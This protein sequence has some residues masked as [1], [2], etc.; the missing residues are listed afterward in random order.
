MSIILLMNWKVKGKVQ[1]KYNHTACHKKVDP[2]DL[3]VKI[4]RAKHRSMQ[5]YLLVGMLLPS[6]IPYRCFFPDIFK[7]L[8][9]GFFLW[10]ITIN[11]IINHHHDTSC[12]YYHK[13]FVFQHKNSIFLVI[14][15]HLLL[16]LIQYRWLCWRY[17]NHWCYVH[18]LHNNKNLY[19]PHT[20]CSFSFQIQSCQ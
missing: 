18:F 15:L 14:A 3:H 7:T 5:R 11:V 20:Y 4:L 17:S 19:H 2:V 8:K 9:N 12:W 10:D 1:S 16:T 6:A 13:Y